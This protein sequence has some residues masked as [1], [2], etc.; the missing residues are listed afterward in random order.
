MRYYT[1]P[2]GRD[3]F[4]RYP[5]GLPIIIDVLL[6]SST[7]V[8]ALW[9]GVDRVIPIV[10]ADKARAVGKE[11]GAVLV[12]ERHGIQI[13]GFDFNSSPLAVLDAGLAGKTVVITTAH[14]TRVMVEGGVIATTLNA[15]A[16]ADRL[17]TAEHTYILASGTGEDLLAARLIESVLGALEDGY[18]A[19]DATR[20]IE[21]DP[22][23]LK[24]L[25][26]IRRS[27]T[28][29]IL[30]WRGHKDDIDFV[31]SAVNRFPIVPVYRN[32]DIK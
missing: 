26:E 21:S 4:L 29:E 15:G 22:Q 9:A 23:C 28:G 5:R 2:K 25:E 11:L 27:E 10:D 18:P 13:D 14:G 8:A 7:I 17:K 6:A 20:F 1:G 12:G 19:G 30:S 16:V 32:C 31:C 24:M 3:K